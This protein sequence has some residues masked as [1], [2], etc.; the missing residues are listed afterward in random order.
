M[1]FEVGSRKAGRP[2]PRG[3]CSAAQ[4]SGSF[5]HSQYIQSVRVSVLKVQRRERTEE[6]N[7]ELL[8][9]ALRKAGR[10]RGE[11]QKASASREGLLGLRVTCSLAIIIPFTL[12]TSLHQGQL[13]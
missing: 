3:L 13:F 4:R 6:R 5:L 7:C 10:L 11:T 2:R 12:L 9:L 8:K 1:P